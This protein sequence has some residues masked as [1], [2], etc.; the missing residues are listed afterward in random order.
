MSRFAGPEVFWYIDKMEK[1]QNL[2]HWESWA[3]EHGAELRATTK[4]ISIKRLEIEAL[5]RR[6]AEFD[7]EESVVLEVG[8]GN[9]FNGFALTETCPGLRYVGADFSPSM[10]ANAM[11]ATGAGRDRM[12]FGVLD[13]RTLGSPLA[14][15]TNAPRSFGHAVESLQ[16][17]KQ[18]DAVFTDRMLIN[19]ASAEEQLVVM[20]RI[21]SVLRPGGI[22][23]MLEN[24][25]E[26]HAQ[27]NE[28]RK[29]LGLSPRL[30]ASYN[31]FID[32]QTV[33]EPFRTDMELVDVEYI[34]GIH[35]LMLY[36]V[37]PATSGGEVQ[38]DSPLMTALTNALLHLRR[39]SGAE[40]TSLGQNVLW[41]W[42]KR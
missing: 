3:G 27:L 29:V 18:F 39:S 15:D 6:I 24:S 21:A 22:F 16:P 35:D 37:G 31:I 40:V 14:F 32:E 17:L 13:A 8:C 34:S 20:R 42:K 11:E 25:R 9:G 2:A 10:I 30:P 38:Y 36:A 23:L 7:L 26:S 41:I 33:I 19:L 28:V 5:T 1:E 12:A 4:C